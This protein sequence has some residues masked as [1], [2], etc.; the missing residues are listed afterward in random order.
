MR[1][2]I[3]KRKKENSRWGAFQLPKRNVFIYNNYLTVPKR[4]KK[5]KRKVRIKQGRRNQHCNKIYSPFASFYAFYT[6]LASA[7]YFVHKS[8]SYI[9]NR[10]LSFSSAYLQLYLLYCL[11]FNWI[12]CTVSFNYFLRFLI[13][14]CFT[15]EFLIFAYAWSYLCVCYFCVQNFS[16]CLPIVW[17]FTV[18]PSDFLIVSLVI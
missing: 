5:G 2:A 9:A 10:I 18:W 17:H 1:I 3:S 8:F 11:F 15:C 7:L 14:I 6:C 13:T 16:S 4:T 12:V